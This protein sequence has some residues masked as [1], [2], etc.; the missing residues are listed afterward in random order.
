MKILIYFSVLIAF[1]QAYTQVDSDNDFVI[2]FFDE[3][4]DN[5]GI[6]DRNEMMCGYG[7]TSAWINSAVNEYS[8]QV[9]GNTITVS[10]SKFS[11]NAGI[12]NFS[13]G[14]MT[15]ANSS[16]FLDPTL[17]NT[18][19]F[20]TDVIW[21][22]HP[23]TPGTDI[24]VSS[25]DKGSLTMTVDFGQLVTNP[26]LH[27][28]RLGGYGGTTSLAYTN[29][30]RFTLT[31][32]G[33]SMTRLAGTNDFQVFGN[34][35]QKRPDVVVTAYTLLTSQ[36]AGDGTAAGSIQFNG[37]ISQ[38]TFTITG[39]GVEGLDRDNI[40]F[41][42]AGDICGDLD[43]DS[44]LIPDRIDLDSDGD[45]CP[46]VVEAGFTDTDGDERLGGL[47]IVVNAVGRVVGPTVVDGYTG[48]LPAVVD[49]FPAMT[50]G[51]SVILPVELCNFTG[52]N[53]G[54]INNISWTLCS[55]TNS[56]NIAL[57]RSFNGQTWE[58]IYEID[59][60]GTTNSAIDYSFIDRTANVSNIAYYRLF[61]ISFDGTSDYSD[62]ISIVSNCNNSAQLFAIKNDCIATAKIDNG[63]PILAL[64]VFDYSGKRVYSFKE[65]E[66][67]EAV[68][69]TLYS[70]NSQLYILKAKTLDGLLLTTKVFL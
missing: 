61:D 14:S 51:C 1:S 16:W 55:Q 68:N 6:T 20:V 5:D 47:P 4:D 19:S 56:K 64:D 23:E 25:D 52:E 21:D 59:G 31:T 60:A 50:I 9:N 3:D 29:S 43:T 42:Y 66:A 45:I 28:E 57:Q 2:D 27:I 38:L 70:E 12:A 33:V 8:S 67:V 69:F 35:F 26:V 10:F 36:N 49:G 18:N 53:A 30:A 17:G 54:C 41:I 39:V 34:S 40:E 7:N 62:A 32:P 15:T 44:D 24:D 37:N 63:T 46:D 65:K 48:T 13:N 11:S 58:T 22:N